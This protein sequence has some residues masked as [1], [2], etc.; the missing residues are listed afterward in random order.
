MRHTKDTSFERNEPPADG[1]S[2]PTPQPRRQRIFTPSLERA[3]TAPKPAFKQVVSPHLIKREISESIEDAIRLP[4]ASGI[5]EPPPPDASGKAKI[6][7]RSGTVVHK[8]LEEVD[9]VHEWSDPEKLENRARR[10]VVVAGA[11]LLGAVVIYALASAFLF[12]AT[13]NEMPAPQ[14]SDTAAASEATPT[15]AVITPTEVIQQGTTAIQQFLE[16]A[17][18]E[19][20]K[21]WLPSQEVPHL[22]SILSRNSPLSPGAQVHVDRAQVCRLGPRPAVLVPVTDRDGLTRIGAAWQVADGK[23]QVDW[24]SLLT[25]QKQSWQD[26]VS[27][28]ASEAALFRLRLEEQPSAD[29]NGPRQLKATLPAANSPAVSIELLPGTRAA[30]DLTALLAAAPA[31][32][33][34]VVEAEV[35][36]QKAADGRV[37]VT[38]YI[39]DRWTLP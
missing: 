13:P 15:V 23:W 34:R 37:T 28:P 7:R 17:T 24:R 33:P 26:F 27:A 6:E 19:D 3:E 5:I 35:Y 32:N 25:P 31:A 14:A 29:A 36:L 21:T 11:V 16:A 2:S 1:E 8:V 30:Q 22:A 18:P 12:R 9:V 39:P 10:S 20:R 38:D 4:L